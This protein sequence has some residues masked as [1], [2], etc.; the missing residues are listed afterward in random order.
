M[1]QPGLNG[2]VLLWGLGRPLAGK[3]NCAGLFAG[4]YA[5]NIDADAMEEP[6]CVEFNDVFLTILYERQSA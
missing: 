4:R 6:D 2:T 5:R 3:Y 1:Q